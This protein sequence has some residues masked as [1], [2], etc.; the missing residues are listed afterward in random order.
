MELVD[1]D[2]LGRLVSTHPV[3]VSRRW[4]TGGLA[5]AIG[6]GGAFL[7]GYLISVSP[8]SGSGRPLLL[9][10][11]PM[12][13]GLPIAVAQ[14]TRAVRGGRKET[15]ELY[16]NGLG[17]HT[18]GGH[19]RWAWEQ[20]AGIRVKT[21]DGTLWVRLGSD[22][23][24]S[25]RFT[26]GTRVWI[27]GHTKDGRLIARTLVARRP[28]VSSPQTDELGS[29]R[30]MR[31]VLPIVIVVSAS[32][33]VLLSRYVNAHDGYHHVPD[34]EGNLQLQ[35]ELSGVEMGLLILAGAVSVIALVASLVLLGIHVL[36][37]LPGR[38]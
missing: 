21:N 28:D 36:I 9:G 8:A 35:P 25:V 7:L 4:R 23:K 11:V 27:D 12:A 20:V 16:E 34:S 3:A 1:G 17:R 32:A 29:W 22:L 38:R 19:R 33:L 13:C 6:L 37:R 24:C 18:S 5:P 31:W 30:V 10:L 14:L 2:R 15:F 26:D